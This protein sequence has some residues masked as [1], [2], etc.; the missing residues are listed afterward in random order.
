MEAKNN[1]KIDKNL[2]LII[3][4][5]FVVLVCFLATLTFSKLSRV[6][7]LK[8]NYSMEESTQKEVCK[9]PNVDCLFAGCNGFY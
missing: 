9:A 6:D 1:K 4:L 3:G 7:S 8:A 5:V 2:A